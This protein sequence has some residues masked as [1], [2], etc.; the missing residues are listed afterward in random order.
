MT[1]HL[2]RR[3]KLAV[4]GQE[5][6]QLVLRKQVQVAASAAAPAGAVAG[7]HPGAA[8]VAGAP[9]AS[10][11]AWPISVALALVQL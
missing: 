8:V 10:A 2:N 5:Q 6:Q 7:A 1:H 4:F 11:V 9:P 3:T